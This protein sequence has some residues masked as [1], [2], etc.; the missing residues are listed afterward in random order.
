MSIRLGGP[1]LKSYRDPDS[2]ARRLCEYGYRAAYC[3]VEPGADEALVRAYV[4]AARTADVVIAEVGAWSNPLSETA[5]ERRAALDRCAACLELADRVGARC[6][7]NIAGSRGAVWDGPHPANFA[8][9]TF[10]MIVETVRDIIDRVKPSGT[11]Y[12][13]ETMPWIW[14]DSPDGYLALIRAVDRERFAVHLD[15]ANMM[16]GPRRLF[17][18]GAFLRE[19]FAKLGP[20]IKS[21]YAK[22]VAIEAKMTLRLNEVRPGAGGIDYRVYLE[23]L[24][25]LEGDTPLML[26]HL[27]D[28]EAYRLAADHVRSLAAEAAISL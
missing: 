28:D 5:E 13:L 2:W 17:R 3:P 23:E 20:Y 4:D 7:V 11:F 26:E 8:P 24:N 21:C 1:V 9:E 12:T 14:P 22:D 27:D 19:C 15:P 18:S 16:T 10:D 6:C 25:K